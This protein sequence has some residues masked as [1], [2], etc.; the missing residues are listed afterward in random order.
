ME[1]TS[2]NTIRLQTAL[3]MELEEKKEQ[4]SSIDYKM[5][6]F[7]LGGKDYA[8][9][10]LR[11]KEIAKADRFTYVPNTAPFVVGVYNLR[12]EII[13]IID[14]RVFFNVETHADDTHSELQNMIIISIGEQ[15]YGIIVDRIEKVAG[16]QKASIQPP[17][18]LF[19]DINI[20][21]IYGIVEHDS[22]M[23]ILLDVARIFGA[24]AAESIEQQEIRI[25]NNVKAPEP[26]KVEPSR[27][28]M[29]DILSGMDLSKNAQPAAPIAV[30]RQAPVASTFISESTITPSVPVSKPDPVVQQAE[31]IP[32]VVETAPIVSEPVIE[33]PQIIEEPTISRKGMDEIEFNFV[34][35]SLK[36]YQNF[37]VNAVNMQWI[38]ERYT[39]WKNIRGEGSPLNDVN[40]AIEFLKPFYS[41]HTGD[42][43]SK[44]YADAV[45]ELLPDNT[46][47]QIT[48]WNPGCAAGYEAYSLA[49]IL[50]KRY[51]ESKIKVYAH[52]TDLILISSA[53][54][55]RIPESMS[56]TWYQPYLSKNVSGETIFSPEI[57]DSILFEYHDCTHLNVVPVADIVFSRD[58]L[59]YVSESKL[60]EVVLD[61]Y[62]KLKDSG[63][64]ILGEHELLTDDS[65]WLEKMYGNIVSYKK[66]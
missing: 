6:A 27:P 34:I 4:H 10:I 25:V 54:M 49:C 30:E 5:V 48:V 35:E 17:H 23:Y 3:N 26:K 37:H 8:I 56:E 63:M 61:F 45:Y 64:I 57:R 44:E 51:P 62:E 55:L 20:K 52:D 41:K 59:S 19:G 50:Q 38:K 18:P 60:D 29:G 58:F 15:K 46:A 31:V 12:G 43:W 65:K 11:V 1:Q 33:A 7:S 28:K 22:R 21:Y 14:L 40:D 9:D 53:P 32:P 39:E 36:R 2:Q 66:L 42:F 47:K 13:P 24:E 16:I